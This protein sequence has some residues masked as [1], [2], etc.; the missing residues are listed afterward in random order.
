MFIIKLKS[1][2]VHSYYQQSFFTKEF[3]EI[4]KEKFK[5]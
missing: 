2:L 4:T 3:G 1:Y 5:T